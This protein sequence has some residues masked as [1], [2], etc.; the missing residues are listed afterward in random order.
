MGSQDSSAYAPQNRLE[1]L[2]DG[3]RLEEPQLALRVRPLQFA[4]DVP[5]LAG[6]AHDSIEDTLGLGG[7]TD[8]SRDEGGLDPNLRDA[9]D[10]LDVEQVRLLLQAYTG[11]SLS[12][13]KARG[14]KTLLDGKMQDC[15]GLD[16][17]IIKY[18]PVIQLLHPHVIHENNSIRLLRLEPSPTEGAMLACWFMDSRLSRSLP[19]EVLTG[20]WG[21]STERRTETILIN[22][23]AAALTRPLAD[24]LRR[25]TPC[26]H[27]PRLLWVQAVCINHGDIQERNAQ[28]RMLRTILQSSQR[29]LVWLGRPAIDSD[30]VFDHLETFG[31]LRHNIR[32]V[33]TDSLSGWYSR[34]SENHGARQQPPKYDVRAAIAVQRLALRPWFYRPWSIAEIALSRDILLICGQATVETRSVDSCGNPFEWF[35]LPYR[36]PTTSIGDLVSGGHTLIDGLRHA[37]HI[38]RKEVV[39]SYNVT[40]KSLVDAYSLVRWCRAADPRD[41]LF[42][43]A[44]LD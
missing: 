1:Q 19:Y 31:A 10:R 15:F 5:S 22:G 36:E 34:Y 40:I 3:T 26:I 41:Y 27:S 9:I 11:P 44:S 37:M 39:R 18:L 21:D 33:N 30:L 14:L 38:S 2:E 20:F 24:A 32:E 16:S 17:F 29:L 25:V 6:P 8:K 43:I 7:P 12:G 4:E 28:V 35:F 23:G 13:Q 42:A